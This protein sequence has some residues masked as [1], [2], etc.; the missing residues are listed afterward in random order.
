MQT[1]EAIVDANGMV[2]LPSNVRLPKNR[3]ALLTVLDEEPTS[4]ASSKKE[5]LLDAFKEAQIANIFR[6]IEDPVEWQRKLRD[7]W[8]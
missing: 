1:I 5:K 2:K 4:T 6:N 7:E 8:E 3:R